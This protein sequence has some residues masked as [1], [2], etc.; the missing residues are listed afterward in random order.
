MTI[1]VSI[2][3]LRAHETKVEQWARTRAEFMATQ[4]TRVFD[5]GSGSVQ[6]THARDAVERWDRENPAPKLIPPV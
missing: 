5:R 2:E 4:A 6:V 1:T 3:E